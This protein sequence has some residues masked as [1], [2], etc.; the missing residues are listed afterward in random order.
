NCQ[1][2]IEQQIYKQR[3]RNQKSKIENSF[4]LPLL[5][6]TRAGYQ[7]LCRM[8]TKMKMRAKKDEGAVREDELR[9]HAAGL[10]CLTGVD[11]GPL[12]LALARGNN[13]KARQSC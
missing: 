5:D 2:A 7:N 8:I 4:R 3:I 13:T 1:F 12:S 9:E 6:S 11:N 10:V